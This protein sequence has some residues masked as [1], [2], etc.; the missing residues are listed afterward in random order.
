MPAGA[1][2]YPESIM[3]SPQ[4]KEIADARGYPIGLIDSSWGG[5]RDEAWSDAAALA[6]CNASLRAETAGAEGTG[7]VAAGD[8]ASAPASAAP[9]SA[10]ALAYGE[11]AAAQLGGSAV[12]SAGVGPNDVS[13]LW[14]SLVVPFLKTAIVGILWYFAPP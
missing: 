1:A 13:A 6:K 14:N 7:P 10:A 8:L 12:V 3:V 11:R 4:G 5:T 2:A 9:A